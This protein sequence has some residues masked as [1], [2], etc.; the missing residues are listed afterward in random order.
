MSASNP[1]YK[2]KEGLIGLEEAADYLSCSHQYLG[3]ILNDEN[4]RHP[5]VDYFRNY[6]GRWRT[7]YTLL[8]EYWTNAKVTGRIEIGSQ[9]GNVDRQIQSVP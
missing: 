2:V 4:Y 5:L 3:K 1:K 8:D 7:T 6:A 9:N